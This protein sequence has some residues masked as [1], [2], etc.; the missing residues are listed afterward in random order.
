MTSL[1]LNNRAL[2][3]FTFK[4]VIHINNTH[5]RTDFFLFVSLFIYIVSESKTQKETVPFQFSKV[6]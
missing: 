5:F 4:I 2:E 1:V 6:F 3:D